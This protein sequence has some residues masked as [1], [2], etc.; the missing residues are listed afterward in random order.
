[1]R[2]CLIVEGSYP[3]VSGGV[4]SWIHS[5]IN[6]MKEHE[7]VIFAIGADTKKRGQF[8]YEL[9]P[10]LIEVKEVFLDEYM[11]E[12]KRWGKR[13]NLSAAEK[14]CL[15]A[16]I[17]GQKT[18][19]WGALFDLIRSEKF[20]NV[21]DFLTSTDY[22]DLVEELGKNTYSEVP[23]TE[24]FWTLSSMILPLFLTIRHNIPEADVYHSVSTGYAGVIASLAKHLY[25]K[26]VIL[27]EHGIYSREREEEIIKADWLKGYFKDL[28]INYFYTLS[29]S[30]YESAD[31]VITLFNRNKE[32]EIELGCKAE[33]IRIIPNGVDIES[34]NNVVAE[35]DDEIIRIGAVI[36]VVPIKDIKTMIQSFALVKQQ[37]PN[38]VLYIM[39]PSEEDKIYDEECK[40]M[41]KSLGVEDVIFT[42]MVQVKDYIV[43]MDVMILT[44]ISEGQ[45]L[46]ILE[47]LASAK[48]FV[49]TNVGGC[50]ELIYGG[51]DDTY[52]AAG[53]VASVM[54]YEEIAGYVIKLCQDRKL[55]ETYGKNGFE[56]VKNEYKRS[57]FI[58]NYREIYH[59]LGGEENGG[60]RL[61]TS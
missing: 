38:S 39:G 55:R 41:V 53:F 27:T 50:K 25:N 32:I 15:A 34:F 1:M 28:W 2:I 5:I 29:S 31:Q 17:N 43:E 22:F 6:E 51:P 3:Y 4:S 13:Y 58:A 52:G 21:G 35:K 42:G 47:G 44:S 18:L 48:P 12:D 8:R 19:N 10:N 14:G 26:P 20:R 61:R 9:P 24:L 46:A 57:E 56:R 59:S 60:Y 16:L 33:K 54:N 37:V 7:F 40:Q 23:F 11:Y 49:C 36:R 45:P 30:I